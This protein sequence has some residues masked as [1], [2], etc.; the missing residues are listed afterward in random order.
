VAALAEGLAELELVRGGRVR[1]Y[2]RTRLT[3]LPQGETIELV[4]GKVFCEIEP[5]HGRFIV[6]TDRGEA[7]VLGTSFVVE[8]LPGG[9]TDV[10]VLSGRVEVEDTGHHGI[11]R[12]SDG[13]RTR[14]AIDA[15]PLPA[16]H[17]DPQTDRMQW[18]Q[19]LRKLGRGL[20]RTLRQL[21]DIF[22]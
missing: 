4:E 15:P 16:L 1:L 19:A 12:V 10:R 7:R 8:K 18:D 20:D 14:L 22:R 2:P 6:H 3:L 9:D 5:G 11:V 21:G 13:Q 17:Y